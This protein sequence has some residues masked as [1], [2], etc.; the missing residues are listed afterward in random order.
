MKTYE[1]LLECGE[2]VKAIGDFCLQA[3]NAFQQSEEYQTAV[4]ADQYYRKHNVTIEKYEKMLYTVTGRKVKDMYSPNHR[5]KTHFFRRMIIQQANYILGAG[6]Q[7]NQPEQK[8]KLGRFFDS[9]VIKAAKIAMVERVAF[10]FW[11]NDHLEVFG[12][13]CTDNHAGFCP[14]YSEDDAGL[15]AGIRFRYKVVGTHKIV[16]MTLYRADGIMEFQKHQSEDVK[17]LSTRKYKRTVRAN[18]A[19]GVLSSY[20]SD[21][22]GLLPIVPLY[23]SDTYESELVGIR[24]AI[25]T[26]DLIKS[27]LANNI[28]EASEI[29][30]IVNNAGGMD[31]VDLAQFLQR[32]KTVHATGVD[33]QSGATAEAHTIDIPTEARKAF[34]ELARTD[35]YDDMMLIDRRTMSAAQKTTQELDMAYQPQDDKVNDFEFFLSD[36]LDGIFAL[37]GVTSEV[38]LRRNKVVNKQENTAMVLSA[39][40]YISPECIIRHLDFLTPEEQ[41]EEIQKYED[42]QHDRFFAQEEEPEEDGTVHDDEG[43]DPDGEGQN[44]GED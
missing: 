41:E 40:N 4:I 44:E 16:F 34:L 5:I 12:Y 20:D 14:L 38:T 35:L 24:E 1:E 27:G 6:V 36:F 23:A 39:A 37:A 43:T 31:D 11:D 25:D 18:K 29:Y 17:L 7:L 2:N 42:E 22:N 15:K 13:C 28:D 10:G 26:Y 3:I 21:Y 19:E 8:D 33:G 9:Q 32:I 30:W